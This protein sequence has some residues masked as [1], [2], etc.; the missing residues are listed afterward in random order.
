[1]KKNNQLNRNLNYSFSFESDHG[2]NLNK[3]RSSVIMKAEAQSNDS[4]QIQIRG[5]KSGSRAS[6]TSKDILNQVLFNS[7]P[8]DDD[9]SDTNIRNGNRVSGVTS[10]SGIN[11]PIHRRASQQS[12]MGKS[13]GGDSDQSMPHKNYKMVPKEHRK[14]YMMQYKSRMGGQDLRPV[15]NSDIIQFDN[16]M[17][18]ERDQVYSSEVQNNLFRE[19]RLQARLRRFEPNQCRICGIVVDYQEGFFSKLLPWD[20]SVI[21]DDET[22]SLKYCHYCMDT[23]TCR[24]CMAEEL[25]YVPRE[26]N[27]MDLPQKRRVCKP[28]YELLKKYTYIKVDKQ[29]PILNLKPD[30][31]QLFVLR[32]I[33][34]KMFDMI[35]CEAWETLIDTKDY[36][37]YKYLVLRDCYLP[38]ELICNPTL[39][40]EKLKSYATLLRNHLKNCTICAIQGQMCKICMDNKNLFYAYDISL[41]AKCKGCYKVGHK[42][43]VRGHHD[44]RLTHEAY[45]QQ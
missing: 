18:L 38:L 4:S 26:I 36:R 42:R 8:D 31:R 37:D 41:V 7:K 30:L 15:S 10:T 23:Q 32:R 43:C 34:H 35:K 9:S 6:T 11:S 5:K 33:V 19:K 21:H 2:K 40:E 3:G 20:N 45:N 12:D 17:Y 1:M 44:C 14:M 39:L 28:A 27:L 13:I 24:A 29:N 25:V 16:F 22:D